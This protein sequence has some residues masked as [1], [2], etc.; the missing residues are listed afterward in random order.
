MG[1]L[2]LNLQHFAEQTTVEPGETL[3]KKQAYWNY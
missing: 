3:L 2:R 1:K